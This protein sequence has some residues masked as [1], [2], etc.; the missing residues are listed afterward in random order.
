MLSYIKFNEFKPLTFQKMLI[1][2]RQQIF[3]LLPQPVFFYSS[4]KYTYLQMILTP[5]QSTEESFRR[6]VV[7]QDTNH[8]DQSSSFFG[9]MNY[10]FFEVSHTI[11]GHLGTTQ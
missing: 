5:M 1:L 10:N 4:T 8:F 3:L 11:F 6:H 2:P 7:R 9:R